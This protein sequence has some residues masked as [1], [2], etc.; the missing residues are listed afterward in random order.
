MKIRRIVS[1]LLIVLLV[2]IAMCTV[3]VR[4]AGFQ[5]YHVDSASMEPSIP[6]GT[7]IYVRH[8]DF[9][10]LQLGDVITFVNSNSDVVTHRI[11]S[12]DYDNEIV[13]TKG[14]ANK[15]EDIQ[16]TTAENIIGKVY[17]QFPYL[18]NISKWMDSF[19]NNRG[20]VMPS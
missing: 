2:A 15:Y 16:P 20:G 1:I 11:I 7:L 13:R 14:D 10:K 8:I 3:G 6:V 19:R 4:V 5:P 12:I 17:L 18:G 9:Q